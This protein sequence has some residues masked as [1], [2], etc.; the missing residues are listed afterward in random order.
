MPIYWIAFCTFISRNS[1]ITQSEWFRLF[2]EKVVYKM[3]WNGMDTSAKVR[4][5]FRAKWPFFCI[6]VVARCF[7]VV[8]AIRTQIKCAI[9]HTSQVMKEKQKTVQRKAFKCRMHTDVLSWLVV[10]DCWP[11][12]CRHTNS[13]LANSDVNRTQDV[14][15]KGSSQ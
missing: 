10:L 3:K 15:W 7:V 1:V 4:L 2:V 8:A 5:A 12:K 14:H 11:P 13:C 9:S 6:F